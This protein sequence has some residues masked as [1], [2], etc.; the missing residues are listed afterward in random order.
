[1]TYEPS[2][3]PS[4]SRSE[5][6]RTI[7]GT[8][9]VRGAAAFLATAVAGQLVGVVDAVAIQRPGAPSAL[10]ARLGWFEFELMNGV[11]VRI[12]ARG[13]GLGALGRSG[14]VHLELGVAL[15]LGTWFAGWLLYRGG[16]AV[17]D[18][19]GGDAIGR[20][21]AGTA[22]APVYAVPSFLLSLAVK[23]PL[24]IP[25]TFI[26]G[27]VEIRSDPFRALLLPLAIGLGAGALGGLSSALRVRP[28]DR[29]I[30]RLWT[31]LSGGWRMFGLGLAFAYLGLFL[32]GVIRPD[33][34]A[35]LATP[36][37]GRY[38]GAVFE[39][40]RDG[41]AVLVHHVAV[42]PDEAV[43]TLV[44]AMGGCDAL[45]DGRARDF[46]CY[47]RFPRR[48]PPSVGLA[49]LLGGGSVFG[50]RYGRAPLPFFL[51]LLVPAAAVLLGGAWTARRSES[52]SWANGSAAG[53]VFA[54]L[55]VVVGFVAS[56]TVGIATSLPI[57]RSA[58][59]RIGP[60]LVS[61]GLLALAWGIVG[62]GL[63]AMIAARSAGD[64]VPIATGTGSTRSSA[65]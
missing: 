12:E 60:E 5:R 48:A 45:A 8:A 10:F 55:V 28:E 27:V 51:F 31:A 54:V 2:T 41:W 34:A 19:A 18:S 61:G 56:V 14:S 9:F 16:R 23:V 40:P 4:R 44:P 43:W 63:G 29:R 35:A 62:G 64:R 13:V 37:T 57:L 39:R 50:L 36:T 3:R 33:G 22:L 46:L 7:A 17:A 53:V 24:R 15:L 32:A 59:Y 38:Y 52:P 25:S 49:S 30:A 65:Q 42:S 20:T 21:I 47:G 58:S 6:A 26:S 11:P 1:V